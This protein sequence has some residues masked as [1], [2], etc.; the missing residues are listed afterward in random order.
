MAAIEWIG[1]RF[2]AP[3]VI[4]SGDVPWRPEVSIRLQAGGPMARLYRAA[5]W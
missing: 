4:T 2:T 1:G 5:P 3:A